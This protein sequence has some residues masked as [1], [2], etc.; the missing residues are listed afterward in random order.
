L[1]R[2]RITLDPVLKILEKGNLEN[3]LRKG[4]EIVDE[5]V[6]LLFDN[7]HNKKS[8]AEWPKL[9]LMFDTWLIV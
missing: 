7:L 4:G 9:H 6:F 5:D 8:P 1:V 2:C 3:A